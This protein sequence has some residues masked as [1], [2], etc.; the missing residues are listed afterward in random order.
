[1]GEV[2]DVVP[3]RGVEVGDSVLLHVN[4]TAFFCGVVRQDAATYQSP[5]LKE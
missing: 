1:M 5:F 3:L 2:A 4:G